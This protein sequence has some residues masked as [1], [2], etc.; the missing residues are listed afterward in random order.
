[1]AR[2]RAKAG[3]SLAAASHRPSGTGF[4]SPTLGSGGEW[5]DGDA[6]P[7]GVNLPHG[8]KQC[9]PAATRQATATMVARLAED[10]EDAEDPE[11]VRR[12]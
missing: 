3:G 6:I 12:P 2:A 11:R 7:D 9:P 8:G 10:A 1:M 4:H 5:K